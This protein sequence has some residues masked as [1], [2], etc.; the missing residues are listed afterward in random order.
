MIRITQKPAATMA[1][2]EIS[3]FTIPFLAPAAIR[4]IK[5]RATITSEK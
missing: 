5:I 4:Q 1:I 2:S 3:S